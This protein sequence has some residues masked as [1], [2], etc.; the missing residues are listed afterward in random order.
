MQASEPYRNLFSPVTLRA[1]LLPSRIVLAP[2][3]TGYARAGC[4]T[5]RLVRFQR[6]RSGTAVGINFLG[7]V[8]TGRTVATNANTAVLCSEREIPRYAVIA[9]AIRSHGSIPAI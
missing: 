6:E 2:I 5:A 1:R 4:P 3:N 9:R 8:A 7:N